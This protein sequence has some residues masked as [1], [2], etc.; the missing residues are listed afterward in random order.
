[1]NKQS[2]IIC[3][4]LLAAFSLHAQDSRSSAD[5]PAKGTWNFKPKKVLEI[6]KAG[7]EEFGRPREQRIGKDGIL[8][9]RDFDKKYS[10]IF[11]PDGKLLKI[12]ASQ[13]GNPPE[14]SMYLNCFIVGDKVVIAAMD[15]LHFYDK[16]GNLIKSI[17]N[18]I[19]ERFP[20]A[21]INENKFY[22]GPGALAGLPQGKGRIVCLDVTNNTETTFMDI[23]LSDSEKKIPPG[24]VILGV[25]PQIL[26]AY[27]EQNQKVYYAKN[28]EYKINIADESGN[29]LGSFGRNIP[30]VYISGEQKKEHMA[31]NLGSQVPVEMMNRMVNNM[32][33]SLTYFHSMIINKGLVYLFRM[34]QFS[35][36]NT[37]QEIDIFSKDGVYL[38]KGILEFKDGTFANMGDVQIKDDIMVVRLVDKEGKPVI[39]K[40]KINVPS[41]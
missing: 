37:T 18:N 2:P 36:L 23:T 16:S 41:K 4:L 15:K 6:T 9:L 26:M 34:T 24:M 20:L 1:M 5:N 38:Y 29:V 35:K 11:S 8:Y 22:L 13:T 3:F 33:D 28:T 14:I 10:C 27:D 12:F 32:P 30:K 21:F 25:I 17:P 31:A 19:F 40:Y 39:A 7:D